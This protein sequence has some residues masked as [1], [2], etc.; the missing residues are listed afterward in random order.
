MHFDSKDLQ[1][2]QQRGIDPQEA[3]QQ[4]SRF[5]RGFPYSRLHAP[6]TVENG[7]LCLDEKL[8]EHYISYYNNHGV[9][10]NCVKFVP[11]SGAAS[12]M[13][14]HLFAFAE[15]HSEKP[16]GWREV[17]EAGGL[18]KEFF[19]RIR[20]FAFYDELKQAGAD[21]KLMIDQGNAAELVETLLGEKGLNY[22][23]LPKALLSFHRYPDGARKAM[24]EHLVEGAMYC[25]DRKSNIKIHMTLSPEHIHL[26][27]ECL[28]AVRGPLEKS[29]GVSFHISHSIQEPSTDTIAVDMDNRPFRD[30]DGRLV[31][32]PGGHGA[33]ISNLGRLDAD[34]VFIKNIDNIVP[35]RLKSTTVT[36]KKALGGLLLE[37]QSRCFGYLQRLNDGSPDQSL[38]D[39]ILDFCRC[40]LMLHISDDLTQNAPEDQRR[41]LIEILNRPM[42]ICGM[43]KNQG[44]PGGGPFWVRDH[45]GGLSLQIIE[46]SQID[47]NDS[48]QAAILRQSTHFNPV[49]LVCTLKDYRGIKFNLSEYS[50]PDTGFI[51][52]KSKDGRPLKAQELPGL[53]NGAMAKWITIFAEVPL[54]TFNPVKTVNDLLRPEHQPE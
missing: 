4:I 40:S 43:V 17:D 31:F 30:K 46:T 23:K 12:R 6:A 39:E 35:D 28:S 5:E 16:A 44:E 51:S 32:R 50:D 26:F 53:W 9:D 29:L 36:Y 13:F 33:L 7:L 34:I 24:T 3:S 25:S 52:V 42:R 19:E 15:Q 49:D 2:L 21:P 45:D 54:I 38:T 14:S 1:E 47:M 10:Q 37:L 20:E 18:V 27:E 22:G 41:K 48:E 8:I 11:A